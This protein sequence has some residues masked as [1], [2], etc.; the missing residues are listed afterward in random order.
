MI[1][2]L[3][4]LKKFIPSQFHKT[5]Y[6]IDFESLYKDGKRLILSDLDNTLIS[7]DEY[8]P[9]KENLELFKQIEDLGLELILLSNNIPPR[10]EKYTKDID[11]LGFANARKPLSIG[12]KKALKNA[13]KEY[14]KEEIVLIGDQLMTD[15]WCANRFGIDSI[16]VNPIKRKTEK[17]Y[18]KFNRKTEVKMLKRLENELPETYKK[19]DLAQ[20]S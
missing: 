19:L 10:L 8:V 18:T 13:K 15:V 7:Y 12:V 2:R 6:E 20:R 1:D 4:K 14:K 17:W 9:T 5:V 16:L 11:I 3:L